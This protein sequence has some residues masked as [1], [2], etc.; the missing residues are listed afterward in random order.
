MFAHLSERLS[1]LNG[2]LKRT[3]TVG[4]VLQ[5]QHTGINNYS[6][7]FRV[8]T[9]GGKMGEHANTHRKTKAEPGLEPGAFLL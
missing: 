5:L 2:G 8:S 3:G 6:I 7:H 1:G 4:G 9:C